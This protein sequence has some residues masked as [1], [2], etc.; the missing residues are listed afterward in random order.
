MVCGKIKAVSHT[1]T[2][3]QRQA[4]KNRH[5]QSGPLQVT[6]ESQ[7]ELLVEMFLRRWQSVW[8]PELP[9]IFICMSNN[10]QTVI[11]QSESPKSTCLPLIHVI[12][13]SLSLHI[14]FKSHIAVLQN[15][16][17]ALTSWC[18]LWRGCWLDS[19]KCSREIRQASACLQW[20]HGALAPPVRAVLA[21]KVSFAESWQIKCKGKHEDYNNS[22]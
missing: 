16:S 7:I 4:D 19:S 18:A 17:F 15:S 14:K 3:R 8:P 2:D 6:R 13:E 11:L 1:Q 9:G 12:L 5:V 20:R 10:T 21:M 22:W